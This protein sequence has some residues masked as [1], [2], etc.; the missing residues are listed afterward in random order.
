MT[1]YPEPLSSRADLSDI[2]A[3]ILRASILSGALR[4]GERLPTEQQMARTYG[5][6]RPVVREA[7][8]RLK[9]DGLVES[10]Q[11]LGAFVSR[12]G[13]AASFR[14]EP[15]LDSVELA[16]I[17]ELRTT[18]EVEAAGLAAQRGT[19]DQIA[20]LYQALT[21]LNRAIDRGEDGSDADAAFHRAVAEASGNHYFSDFMGFLEARVR[22]SIAAARR[23]SARHEGWEH[24]VQEEHT[25][26]YRDIA[27]RDA[28]AAR[29]AMREH[30]LNAAQR[31]ALRL[32]MTQEEGGVS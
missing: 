16:L 8:A 20:A 9:S 2:L 3:R 11:G 32:T 19:R 6:S 27:T 13:G 17:F 21:R 30:L 28:D 23:N 7:I 26:V 5:V 18:V 4:P 14:I 25:R 12:L 31:L 15:E 10:R 22:S 1:T 24:K 29:E